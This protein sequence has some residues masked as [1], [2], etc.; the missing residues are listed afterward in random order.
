[1]QYY[2]LYNGIDPSHH[3]WNAVST[4]EWPSMSYST[5]DPPINNIPA[6]PRPEDTPNKEPIKPQQPGLT[7]SPDPTKA[8][9]HR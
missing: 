1:M 6:A 4:P 3:S 7:C 2:Y 5:N 8:K 9:A